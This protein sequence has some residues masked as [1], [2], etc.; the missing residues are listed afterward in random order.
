MKICTKYILKQFFAYTFISLMLFTFI[1]LMDRVFQ[2]VNLMINKGVSLSNIAGLL[3]LSL[4]TIIVLAAPMATLAAGILTFG[5][6]ASD[7]EITAIRTSGNTLK[8]LYL[9]LAAAVIILTAFMFPFNYNI[10]P[11]SQMAFRE[12]FF[13]LAFKDPTLNIEESTLVKVEPYTLLCFDVNRK[14]RTMKEVIIY[15]E[16]DEGEPAVSITAREGTWETG[17]NGE[18]VL[19][20]SDGTIKQQPEAKP[21]ALRIIN[22]DS[23]TLVLRTPKEGKSPNKSIETMTAEELKEEINRLKEKN[24]P[25]HKIE[26][27][28][29]LRGS[30]AGAIPALLLIGIPLGIR[31][32]GRGKTIGIGMSIGVIA[33]YYFM[34]V[35]GIKLSFNR[36]L[37]PWLGIWLPNMITAAAGL[38]LTIKSYY[39]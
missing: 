23:Y 15:K 27:R 30:L 14:K 33:V 12:K 34:M 35:A 13:E 18:I 21:E 38:Y 8:P 24:L 17:P 31:A 26:T 5:R 25:S 3:A 29:H 7:G 10:A 6:M 22:F 11:R 16:A 2:L 36:T 32:E 28:F 1:L 4:P 37:T 20:L 9:P 39:K 19:E